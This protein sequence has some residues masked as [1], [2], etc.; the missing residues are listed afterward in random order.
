MTHQIVTWDFPTGQPLS[1]LEECIV[2][3][4]A[5]HAAKEGRAPTLAEPSAAAAQALDR[6]FPSARRE[7][8]ERAR[9]AREEPG[10]S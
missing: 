5:R 1:S 10:A 9:L 2:R 4:N 8:R 7:L 6:E 3:S